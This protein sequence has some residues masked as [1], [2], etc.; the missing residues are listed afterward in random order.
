MSFMSQR[1]FGLRYLN[2]SALSISSHVPSQVLRGHVA[3]SRIY[4]DVFWARFHAKARQAL[5]LLYCEGRRT[6]YGLVYLS[7]TTPWRF[8]YDPNVLAVSRA[9]G[10]S[11][12]L[13]GDLSYPKLAAIVRLGYRSPR[14]LELQKQR[15]ELLAREELTA[16]DAKQLN[17]I[18][19]E[20]D[21]LPQGE[22]KWLFDAPQV[23]R[24]AAKEI[25]SE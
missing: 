24:Q 18:R 4:D 13:A 1:L 12:K 11:H 15:D 25:K 17:A 20:L 19:D 5:S 3:H 6:A 7:I 23:I 8:G 14:V 9:V 22:S 2:A 10:M 21:T 16:E